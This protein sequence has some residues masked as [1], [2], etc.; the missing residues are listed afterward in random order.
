[1]PSPSTWNNDFSDLLF[2]PCVALAPNLN[3]NDACPKAETTC[4]LGPRTPCSCDNPPPVDGADEEDGENEKLSEENNAGGAGD[5]EREDPLD[6]EGDEG[7]YG[8]GEW[9]RDAFFDLGMQA[10]FGFELAGVADEGVA[11]GEQS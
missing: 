11:G 6:G 5:G 3:L 10:Q 4:A 2:L 1:M 7:G 9:E 8:E